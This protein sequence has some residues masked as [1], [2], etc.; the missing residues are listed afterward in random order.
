MGTIYQTVSWYK[1]F[2]EDK[3]DVFK[4]T[5]NQISDYTNTATMKNLSWTNAK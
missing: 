5:L 4:T 2:Y 3:Y 1:N